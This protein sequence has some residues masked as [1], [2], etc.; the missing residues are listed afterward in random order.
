MPSNYIHKWFNF[1]RLLVEYRHRFLVENTGT[2]K[3][4]VSI[5]IWHFISVRV[6]FYVQCK[7][8]FTLVMCKDLRHANSIWLR[9]RFNMF[10]K[11]TLN[12]VVN[13][14]KSTLKQRRFFRI[15]FTSV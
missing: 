14:I 7:R 5:V 2:H 3:E 10:R 4:V 8:D 1:S 15:L 13:K 6:L 9:V 12:S 11:A